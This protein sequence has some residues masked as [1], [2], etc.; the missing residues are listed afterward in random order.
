MKK[1]LIPLIGV[2]LFSVCGK[3]IIVEAESLNG[4]KAVRNRSG[5]SA[6]AFCGK[7][8]RLNGSVNI[9][10]SGIWYVWVRYC[11][12]WKQW[13]S[14]FGAL[15]AKKLRSFRLTAGKNT[16]LFETSTN[17]PWGWGR[18]R[19]SLP[20]G[21]IPLTLSAVGGDPYVDVMIFTRN[22]AFI[23]KLNYSK[24]PDEITG[25]VK[26]PKTRFSLKI[27]RSSTFAESS[28]FVIRS[29][30][31]AR[32]KTTALLRHDGRTLF[33]KIRCMQKKSSL[34]IHK[35][36]PWKQDSVEFVLDGNRSLNTIRHIII[37]PDN[38]IFSTKNGMPWQCSW[39]R[40]AEIKND[41]W[42]VELEI[43]LNHRK[44]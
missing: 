10:E 30:D 44:E 35:G 20:K 43:P 38:R 13:E 26:I 9:P 8:K 23:P 6:N 17:T 37:T 40:K 29:G 16:L 32:T 11:H 28:P 36:A 25:A 31:K 2:L 7:W 14:R 1:V 27:P 12:S 4:K 39:R 18:R 33:A 3:N 21:K 24:I 41:Y 42:S 15:N 19:I 22:P 5:Y 34:K